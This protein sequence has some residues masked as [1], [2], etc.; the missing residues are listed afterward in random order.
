MSDD[1]IE[2]LRTE[3]SN[4]DMDNEAA[5]AL[6][7]QAKRIAELEVEVADLRDQ[8]KRDEVY[9]TETV[10]IYRDRAE[11]AEADLAAAR[12][13]KDDVAEVVK[14]AMVWALKQR[15]RPEGALSGPLWEAAH[16]AARA[17]GGE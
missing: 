1:L 7:A 5:D 10:Q 2:R 9:F 8:Y 14:R 17:D 11:K 12:A 4:P 15:F 16:A 6:E 3:T 13:Y